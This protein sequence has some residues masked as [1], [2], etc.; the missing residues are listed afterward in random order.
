M[1]AVLATISSNNNLSMWEDK[2]KLDN[3]RV[4]F[5]PTLLP[6]EFEYFVEM[7]KATGLNPFLKEIWCVSYPAGKDG[8]KKAA[9]VFIG[10]D[11]Y[12]KAAQRHKDYDYHQADAVHEND[13]F[14]VV[15]GEIR[16][17]YTLK[18]R[19]S[20]IGAY[21]IVKSKKSSRPMYVYVPLE[22]YSTGQS[23][24][25]TPGEYVDSYGNKKPSGGKPSTM[26]KKVAEAQ[27][28]RTV[29][30]DLFGGTYEREEIPHDNH[31]NERVIEFKAETQTEKL[32]EIIKDVD[33]ETGEIKEPIKIH[34]TGRDDIQCSR[35]QM[36]EISMIML[37]KGFSEDRI[38]RALGYYKVET[39]EQL[40]D[41]QAR[42]FLLQLGKA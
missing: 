2:T 24:W 15:D 27:A 34:N 14:E 38:R 23:L 40:T 16:H 6:A 30:Q 19:G 39:L 42:L 20:L 4:L 9:Q 28:L 33:M 10:R 25:K 36:E 37:D 12:R 32:K 7:G 1:S 41:A 22:E 35:E 26:I 3:I 21:C 29:F 11:G 5:A 31:D 17:R 13:V 18:N 8:K